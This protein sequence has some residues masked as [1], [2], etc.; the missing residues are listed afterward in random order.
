MASRNVF[1]CGGFHVR[2]TDLPSTDKLV[3]H[4]GCVKRFNGSTV[5]VYA[6]QIWSHKGISMNALAQRS[7]GIKIGFAG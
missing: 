7:S 6:W 2:L 4:W 3:G 5:N 1:G